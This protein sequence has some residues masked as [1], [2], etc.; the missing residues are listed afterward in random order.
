MFLE[1]AKLTTF[2]RFD[3]THAKQVE[4]EKQIWRAEEKIGSFEQGKIASER[5]V[6]KVRRKDGPRQVLKV[7]FLL[8]NSLREPGAGEGIHSPRVKKSPVL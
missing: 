7:Q 8:Q 1:S 6:S 4:V 5:Q 3:A 2:Q